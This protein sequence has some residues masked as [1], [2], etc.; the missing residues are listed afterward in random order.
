MAGMGVSKQLPIKRDCSWIPPKFENALVGT[1]DCSSDPTDHLPNGGYNCIA[2]AAGKTDVWWWPT[3]DP[4]AFWPAGLDRE[5]PGEE[6]IDNFIK[7]FK[8]E[9]YIRCKNGKFKRG[10][11][12]VAIYATDK[13]IPTH[14]A[15]SLPKRV[16]TSKMGS[17]EDIEHKTLS[18]VEGK[19]YGKAVKFLKRRLDKKPFLSQRIW[20][21][22][23]GFF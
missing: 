16:W 15:R 5:A 22:F 4:S 17:G 3:D 18:V 9:G 1:F 2:W 14:A 12:K 21:F 8:R 23:R 7:A 20:S 10:I 13:G 6:T 19:E 11:E